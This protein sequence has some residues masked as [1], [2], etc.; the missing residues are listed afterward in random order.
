MDDGP[1]VAVAPPISG[2][3]EVPGAE[4]DGDDSDDAELGDG[5]AE[6]AD[7]GAADVGE[8]GAADVGGGSDADADVGA[9]LVGA[10]ADVVE[11]GATTEKLG[12][13]ATKLLVALSANWIAHWPT[14]MLPAMREVCDRSDGLVSESR[15]AP[16]PPPAGQMVI[17]KSPGEPDT[18]SQVI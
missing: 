16:V 10:A 12:D 17:V 5:A 4:A 18:M 1:R 11:V 2:V 3:E 8:A 14:G 7:V 15:M 6:D 9:A 13:R